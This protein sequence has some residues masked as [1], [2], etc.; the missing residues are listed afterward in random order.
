MA[1][2]RSQLPVYVLYMSDE[3]NKGGY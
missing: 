1:S 2:G 3:I